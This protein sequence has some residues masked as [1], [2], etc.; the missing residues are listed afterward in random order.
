MHSL[1]ID[2]RVGADWFEHVLVDHDVCSNY[3]EWG[4]MAN[5]AS[6][7]FPLGLKGRGPKSQT[8]AGSPWA[9]G[10]QAGAA[11]FDPKEQQAT[12]ARI[13]A[14]MGRK[15]RNSSTF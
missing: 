1:G 12:S 14:I 7:A 10:V 11:V 4:S 9:K 5:V 13:F 15:A 6:A 2:W 3:G 8:K